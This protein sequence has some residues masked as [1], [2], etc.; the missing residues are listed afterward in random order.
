[1]C[2]CVHIHRMWLFL[3][4][5]DAVWEFWKVAT[6][7]KKKKKKKKEE[8]MLRAKWGVGVGGGWQ[9]GWCT[10]KAT[11]RQVQG[12]KKKR[13]IPQFGDPLLSFFFFFFSFLAFT[14]VCWPWWPAVCR[15][16][17][18]LLSPSA[19]TRT[20]TQPSLR[21][22]LLRTHDSRAQ[23]TSLPDWAKFPC[24]PLPACARQNSSLLPF[25]LSAP[26][27]LQ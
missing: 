15:D 5:D 13:S 24:L 4:G 18:S 1:M 16:D 25:P 9:A 2:V 11:V 20:P 12:R 14:P 19:P 21:P 27:D 6:Y 26:D 17:A 22:S 23:A 8:W 7:L 10:V 3:E